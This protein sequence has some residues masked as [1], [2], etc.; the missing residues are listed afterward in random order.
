MQQLATFLKQYGIEPGHPTSLIVIVGIIFLTALIV[1]F[2]LHRIV[3]RAFERRAQGSNRLWLQIIT[4]N[5]LFH[6]LAF[7]LQGMIV[8][9]Q[10]VLWLEK[11]SDAALILSTCAQLWVMIYALMSFFSLLD[12][13]AG[14]SHRFAFAAQFP[15]KGSSRA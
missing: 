6:R 10:A 14:L 8:N 13:I 9:L 11:G 12:V 15:L 4:G 7:M 2:I 3:L 1:H 5:K